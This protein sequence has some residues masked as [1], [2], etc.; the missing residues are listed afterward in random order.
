MLYKYFSR[1]EHGPKKC[2]VLQ[3]IMPFLRRKS[4]QAVEIF[5]GTW[6]MTISLRITATVTVYGC[7]GPKFLIQQLS[8]C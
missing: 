5:L 6:P 7:N 2:L 3:Q 1:E 4:E 8:M